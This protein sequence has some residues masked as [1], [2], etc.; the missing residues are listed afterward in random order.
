MTISSSFVSQENVFQG[1]KILLGVTGSVAAYKA[2]GLASRLVKRGA[3]VKVVLTK[4]GTQFITALAFS[5]ITLDEVYSSMFPESPSLAA[6][7]H[8]SL[9]READL[10]LV[11]PATANIIAKMAHG[12]A[13]DLLS[14]LLLVGGP[15]VVMAPAMNTSMYLQEVTQKNISLLEERGVVFLGPEEGDLAC[16]EYGVGRL[17]EEE[18]A[19]EEIDLLL[20]R[21]AQ[22]KGKKFLITA[23]GTREP[24]DPVRFI[25]N[26][27]SGKMGKYLAEEA[28]ARGAEVIFLKAPMNVPPPARA[29]LIEV[30]TAQEMY[31]EALRVFPEVD[32]VVM[33][34]AVSDFYPAEKMEEKISKKERKKLTLALL[35][36][37][38]IL[39]EMG[40]RKER[41]FLVGFSAETGQALDRAREKMRDKALDMIVVN[42]VSRKDIGF[43]SDFNQVTILHQ[44]GA[45]R[46]TPRVHKRLISRVVMDEIVARL[47][48]RN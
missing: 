18:R 8:L 3:K 48:D 6:H 28:L 41:Q 23:G 35:P 15:P 17:V 9:A 14:T 25:T 24:I 42:D 44:D 36:T 33:A 31:Q 11:Y 43:G 47:S 21:S 1:K 13:D 40:K 20:R 37:P 22:L 34:A 16:G 4:A 2:V 38:D 27:S 19:I 12:L 26:R 46:E 30:E 29:H 5:S 7:L 39:A 32:V 10:I 45:Q